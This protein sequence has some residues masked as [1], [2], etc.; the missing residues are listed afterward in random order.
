[1]RASSTSLW[2]A[3]ATI[4]LGGWILAIA[5]GLAP[6]DSAAFNAPRWVVGLCGIVFIA[7]GG[8][9]FGARWPR[10]RAVSLSLLLISMGGAAAWAALF[11]PSEG[12][13]GGVPFLSD[14]ANVLIA[15]SFA[16]L[17]MLLCAGLLVYGWKTGF[18]STADAANPSGR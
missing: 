16:S 14:A 15:R 2:L 13:S 7:G 17:G 18:R 1:M 12:W 11:A 4:G 9:M 3:A 8:A 6:A 5:T 10:L